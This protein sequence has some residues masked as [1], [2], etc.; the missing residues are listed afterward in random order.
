MFP[1]PKEEAKCRVVMHLKGEV[2]V[3]GGAEGASLLQ[4]VQQYQ[5]DN[6]A[7]AKLAS[8]V[9]EMWEDVP[10]SPRGKKGVP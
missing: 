7:M 6:A 10:S 4:Q 2:A 3:P 5:D 1:K 9:I 8:A